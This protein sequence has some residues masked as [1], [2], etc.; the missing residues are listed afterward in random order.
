MKKLLATIVIVGLILIGSVSFAE[1]RL[2]TEVKIPTLS[3][4]MTTTDVKTAIEMRPVS[5][6]EYFDFSVDFVMT[7]MAKLVKTTQPAYLL[8]GKAGVQISI[9][10]QPSFNV[11]W[12][13]CQDG[14]Q[15]YGIEIKGLP[16]SGALWGIFEKLHPL[17]IYYGNKD[18]TFGITYEFRGE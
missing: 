7:V 12:G 16:L 1:E 9:Y 10:E 8:N 17:I 5:L 18:I 6:T 13:L 14:L 11:V 3:L 2:T 4:E 15:F